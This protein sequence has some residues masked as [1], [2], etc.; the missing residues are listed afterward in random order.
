MK[1]SLS[2]VLLASLLAFAGGCAHDHSH[3][4]HDHSHDGH[5]HGP[6]AASASTPT[7]SA[8]PP[9]AREPM[10]TPKPLQRPAP[11]HTVV[12]ANPNKPLVAFRFVFQAGSVDD[13]KGKE[14]LT[15]LTASM[16][17]EGGTQAL[18]SS[19]LLDALFPM[20]AQL[21]VR[22]DKQMTTFSG[23]V[24]K[25]NLERFTE[26]F[27][28]VLTRP[29]WDAKELERLRTDAINTI[30]NRLRTADD[31]TLGKLALEQ[32]LYAGHPYRHATVGTV[33]GLRSITLDDVK[34]QAQRVFTQDRLVLGV[35]GAIDDAFVTK[36]KEK[37]AA[38]PAKGA[39]LVAIPA[40]R[41][42]KN[43]AVVMQKNGLSTAISMGYAY[44]LRRGD[45]DFF[46]TA[47]ALS[48]LGE[49]RQLLGVL[50]ASCAKSAASTT[51]TTPTSS[52]SSRRAAARTP[53]RTS[54]APSRTSR[55][56]FAPSSPRT[57]SSRRAARS[58]ISTGS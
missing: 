18:S 7:A 13:P 28:D 36:L 45:P 25:D 21:S 44:G 32:L 56:G 50:S 29:R 1:T 19:Q 43:N 42:L 3:H 23:R 37:L 12:H 14:G 34:A 22:T 15:D 10:L 58:T 33:Q 5:D 6:A 24:H 27:V 40:V 57:P 9:S 35:A 8:T 16:M 53:S 20:A 47:V 30:Q 31:E 49:H 48:H 55:C 2:H 11:L 38:L 4:D 39:A 26:I 17:A 51:G 54:R 46:P 41:Q 52:T